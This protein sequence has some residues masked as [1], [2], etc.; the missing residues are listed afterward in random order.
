MEADEGF[1][2]GRLPEARKGLPGDKAIKLG[3]HFIN[4]DPILQIFGRSDVVPLIN[5]GPAH[6]GRPILAGRA[7]PGGRSTA[8]MDRL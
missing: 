8:A 3:K 5:H 6:V 7:I 4:L 1:N 2:N